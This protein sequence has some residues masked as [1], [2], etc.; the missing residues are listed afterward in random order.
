MKKKLLIVSLVTVSILMS[1]GCNNNQTKKYTCK[2]NDSSDGIRYLT[3][4]TIEL[5]NKKEPIK[6]IL[7]DGFGNYKDNEEAYKKFCEGLKKAEENNKTKYSKEDLTYTVTCDD[8]KKEAYYIVTYNLSNIKDKTEFRNIN[9]EIEK[10]TKKDGTF[11]LDAWKEYF[12][13]SESKKGH[14]DCDF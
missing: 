1:T 10:Y 14:Y 9:T 12:N 2:N 5:N 6:Y 7:K 4:Y 8:K 3:T 11:D 13:T